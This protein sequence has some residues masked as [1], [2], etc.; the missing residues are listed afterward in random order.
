LLEL[1]IER[2]ALT[3]NGEPKFW[4]AN[5]E[6]ARMLGDTKMA[7]AAIIFRSLKVII[8]I[9]TSLVLAFATIL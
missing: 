6:F 8:V 2:A 5:A 4:V 9:Q 3:P 7:A 1:L